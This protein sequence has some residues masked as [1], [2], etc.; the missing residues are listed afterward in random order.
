MQKNSSAFIKIWESPDDDATSL[1]A[2]DQL[3]DISL[4]PPMGRKGH[5]PPGR[6][7]E[8]PTNGSVT[9]FLSG[10]RGQNDYKIM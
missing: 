1:E 3:I 6:A 5:S 9:P 4:C 7:G 2:S 8:L 10:G